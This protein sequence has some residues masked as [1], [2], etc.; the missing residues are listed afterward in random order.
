MKKR[1][2][3]DKNTKIKWKK[4]IMKKQKRA[5]KLPL[6]NSLT[7]ITKLKIYTQKK[8]LRLKKKIQILNQVIES[9]W[10]QTNIMNLLQDTKKTKPNSKECNFCNWIG[11]FDKFGSFTWKEDLKKTKCSKSNVIFIKQF[12]ENLTICN[13][14]KRSYIF[15]RCNLLHNLQTNT[16]RR[17]R[18][19][20]QCQTLVTC[21]N[22]L[23]TPAHPT[24]TSTP[25]RLPV[26]ITWTVFPR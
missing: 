26:R 25:H 23:V 17:R 13:D 16:H 5:W 6:K 7:N 2:N 15:N 18:V 9:F 3:R 20:N 19:K 10:M 11:K 1:L 14:K 8:Q 12:I 24:S 22:L 4:R 21:T